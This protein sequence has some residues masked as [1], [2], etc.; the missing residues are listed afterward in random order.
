MQEKMD[1]CLLGLIL[2]LIFSGTDRSVSVSTV[3]GT[4]I[5]QY[6]LSDARFMQHCWPRDK[7]EKKRHQWD[8]KMS[9]FF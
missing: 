3:M 8:M 5:K 4:K 7:R 6:R 2:D 9:Y 1:G